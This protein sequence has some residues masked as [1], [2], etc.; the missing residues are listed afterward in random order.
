M[1]WL[2]TKV[3]VVRRCCMRIVFVCLCDDPRDAMKHTDALFLRALDAAD[4]HPPGVACA[5]CGSVE[6]LPCEDYPSARRVK[7]PSIAPALLILAVVVQ[8]LEVGAVHGAP[9]HYPCQRALPRICLCLAQCL[10]L[11]GTGGCVSGSAHKCLTKLYP[12]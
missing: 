7:V 8:G 6:E 9:A 3:A 2:I 1:C 5:H 4:A 10:I 11:I 12:D